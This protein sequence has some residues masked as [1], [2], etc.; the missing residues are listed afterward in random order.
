[1]PFRGE[2]DD[3]LP[4][5]HHHRRRRQVDADLHETRPTGRH[6]K[7]E[8]KFAESGK[9]SEWNYDVHFLAPRL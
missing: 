8:F 9:Q 7:L 2:S 3:L 5:Q 6:N 1:M 4:R